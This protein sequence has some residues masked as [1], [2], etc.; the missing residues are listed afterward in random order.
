MPNIKLHRGVT[1]IEGRPEL[2]A[3]LRAK[4]VFEG[5]AH[6]ALSPFAV[7]LE[8]DEVEELVERLLSLGYS[9]GLG[10]R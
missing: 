5:F 6:E 3:E 10:E 2:L 9:P 1:V 8:E 4:G 7:A